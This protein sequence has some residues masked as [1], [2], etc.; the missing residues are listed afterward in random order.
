MNLNKIKSILKVLIARFYLALLGLGIRSLQ[1]SKW[2]PNLRTLFIFIFSAA[3]TL[4]AQAGD[5]EKLQDIRKFFKL[6]NVAELS[7]A[8]IENNAEIQRRANP[9][10]PAEFWDEL[11]K[12]LKPAEL[13]ERMVPIYDKYFSHD[14]IRA[15]I[16]F[17]E[18]TAG[19]AFLES[20]QQVLKE[21]ALAGQ[22]YVQ[23]VG[24]PI[25]KRMQK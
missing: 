24:G 7:F 23:E 14:E 17:F 13:I 1:I 25:L 2:A 12:E 18:S 4:Q 11:L 22:A 15:W 16:V 5:A 9:Q 19:Q 6:T 10:I 3:L 20:Q 21:S 8:D